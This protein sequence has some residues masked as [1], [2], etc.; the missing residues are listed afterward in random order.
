M[1]SCNI[2]PSN[3][4]LSLL[5]LSPSL[6]PSLCT[7]RGYHDFSHFAL[8]RLVDIMPLDTVTT[9]IFLW[10]QREKQLSLHMICFCFPCWHGTLLQKL[11]STKPLETSAKWFIL[12]RKAEMR[13]HIYIFETKS[14]ISY[15]K[16]R[17]TNVAWSNAKGFVKQIKVLQGSCC[18]F[19][20]NSQMLRS[21]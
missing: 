11:S 17:V 19:T 20:N 4:D 21:M 16:P 9:N 18:S 14:K 15:P 5:L 1:I 2:Y 13:L 7:Y 3:I 6:W 10:I 12:L 8:F